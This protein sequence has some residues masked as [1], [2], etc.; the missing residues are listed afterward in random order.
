MGNVCFV[1]LQGGEILE[2]LP[3]APAG[4]INHSYTFLAGYEYEI[5]MASYLLT[6]NAVG[7]NRAPVFELID[8]AANLLWRICFSINTTANELAR[9]S[10]YVGCRR[11]N[12]SLIVAP[13]HYYND[14][15]PA[16]RILPG[17][18]FQSAF[19]GLNI[20]DLFSEIRFVCYRWRT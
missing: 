12:F 20:G 19:T 10:L 5:R 14:A 8:A 17:C 16:M 6:T 4:G 1:P 2:I 13:N 15:L 7:G 11:S 18:I 9:F 3:L